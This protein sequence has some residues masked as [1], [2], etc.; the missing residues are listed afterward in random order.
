MVTEQALIIC[1]SIHHRN[2]MKVAK[3]MRE[4][5]D[6]V[7]VTPEIIDEVI[8]DT[9]DLIGL[10]SGIYNGRHH[11]SIYEILET[12]PFR[13]HQRVF[14]FS[15]AAL[16]SSHYHEPLKEILYAKEY[17]FVG[18]FACKGYTNHSFTKA[19]FGGIN[20]DHPN[21]NDLLNA[22]AFAKG[23]LVPDR[24]LTS[25]NSLSQA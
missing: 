2:T 25:V 8:P 18:E 19:F 9:Y 6:A 14:V 13:R 7:I 17:E 20:K 3:A 10:G 1:A 11:Q 21:D 24:L 23:L 12:V 22:R 5:L 16:R 4:E 15:T